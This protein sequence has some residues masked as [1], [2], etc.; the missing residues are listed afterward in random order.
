MFLERL[1]LTNFQCFGPVATTVRFDR[2]L[3]AMLGANAAGKTA[4]C[5]ALLRLF[6]VVGD[7]RRIRVEDFHVPNDEDEAPATRS[8]MIEAV[9]AFPELDDDTDAAVASSSVPEFFRQMT[10][11]DDGQLKLRIVLEASWSADG[12]VV[13]TIDESCRVV[14]TFDEDYGAQWVEFRTPDRN[15]IQMVYVP[16]NR[17]GA[18]Q[19]AAFLRGRVWRASQWS[20]PFREH[21]S[22]AAADLSEKFKDEAVVD[23]VTRAIAARWQALHHL[24]S[25]RTPMFEPISR[26]VSVLVTNAEMLFELSP[27]GRTRSAQELSDGQRSLLHIALTAATLDLEGAIAAGEH[28]DKFDITQ[29][30]LPS[31]TLLAI[32]EPENNLAPFFLSRVVEQLLDVTVSG[33]AQAI[34]SSHSASVM[35]RIPTEKVRHFRLDEATRTTRVCEIVLPDDTTEAGKYVREAVRAYPELYFAR[36]VVLGEG[37]SEQVVL[38]KLAEARG[39][40][41]D[42]SFV[43]I[44]PLGGRHTNHFWRLLSQLGIPYATLLDLDWGR[45]GGGEGRIRDACT[46][47]LAVDINPFDGC[48]AIDSFSSTADIADLTV[49]QLKAWL[50]HLE[51]WN[52]YFSTPLDLDMLLLAQFKSAYTDHLDEGQRGP[53]DQGDPRDAVLGDPGVRPDVA[54]W[55]REQMTD[56]LRWYRYL[57]LT[58]S[59]PSTHLRALSYVGSGDLANVKGR[60]ARLLDRVGQAVTPK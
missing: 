16:A 22:S 21:V 3:T 26:D 56:D 7:Q 29:T 23:T 8:L 36:F 41:I 32:E 55:T 13:G 6:S 4:A 14:H 17:D 37:D 57:F 19:V 38:P 60:L 34:I 45:A 33:R 53:S 18:R 39:L 42:Q 12:S 40:Y 51:K 9:F 44:V 54:H 58:H 28:E 46:Q 10:A 1:T 48:E 15:R 49:D 35:S 30:A 5:Q 27:T 59:K 2:Q 11:D 25:E 50:N 43:A 52:I 20:D 47:L 31:L 24:V